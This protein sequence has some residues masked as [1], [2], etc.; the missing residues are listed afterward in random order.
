VQFGTFNVDLRSGELRKGGV[1]VKLYGQ[2]FNVLAA[3]L[4]RPGQVVTREELQQK[5]WAGDTFVDFEHGLN[6]AIN[7]VREALGDDADN[8]RF[9]ETLP[10]RGYRFIAP[11]EETSTGR[12]GTETPLARKRAQW[13]VVAGAVAVVLAVGGYLYIHRAPKL[14]EKDSII[15][16]DF[17]NTT[18]DSVFD[19]TLRQGLSIQLEQ[20]PFFNILSGD[21]ITE[22]IG[23]MEKPPDTNLTPKVAREVCERLN[24]RAEIEGSIAAL[25]KQYV[26]GLRAINCHTGETLAEEQVTA[27]GKTTVLAA[28]GQAA[29]ELRSKLGESR[30]SLKTYDVPL[31]QATTASL[32]ALQAFN[33]CEQEFF[34]ADYLAAISFCQ[35]A[36]TI[37][38]NFANPYGLLGIL[39][40]ISQQN[41]LQVEAIRKAYYLRDRTSEREKLLIL[42]TYHLMGTQ[43]LEKEVQVC[44]QYAQ[45]YPHDQRAFIGLGN[46]HRLLGRY[47]QAIAG[48]QEVLRL[49]PTVTIAYENLAMSYISLNHLDKARSTIE[50]ARARSLDSLDFGFLLYEIEFLQGSAAGMAEQAPHLSTWQ[51]LFLEEGTASYSGQLSYSRSVIRS[52]I[53]AATKANVKQVAAG[54]AADSSGHEA[55]FG[56]LAEARSAASEALRLKREFTDWDTE[57][58]AAFSLALAGDAAQAE[59]LAADLNRQLP[60][61]TFMQFVYLPAIRAAVAL[62][63]GSAHEAIETLRVASPYELTPDGIFSV[64][65]RGQAYL[66]ARQGKEAA[67][68]FQKI[69]DHPGLVLIQPIGPLAHLGLARAYAMQSDTVKARAAYQDFVGLW[70][71]ADPDIPVLKQAKAEFAR[72]Q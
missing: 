5:L 32:D 1:K 47:D 29:S 7:K 33:R 25:D 41:D 17:M 39:Y 2:P 13:L 62:H 35:H 45:T 3:L 18:G 42:C 61:G 55:L 64:Y 11:V 4:E 53:A 48:H 56:N 67:V 66:T 72:L 69:L 24:A 10:R 71:D 19:G 28:L 14:T 21:K 60:Q 59:T 63:Q 27:G 54:L 16:A 50:S 34:R 40:A 65:L 15:I 52:G 37:D 44:R 36:V 70:K 22:Q 6:K 9:I 57:G 30:P 31:V 8:P 23:L 58:V 46:G 43:D 68:E 12:L 49:D 38:P 51:R 20:S 26:I